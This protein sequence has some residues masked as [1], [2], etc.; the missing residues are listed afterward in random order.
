MRHAMISRSTIV[1]AALCLLTNPL[2][3][4]D[5]YI[6][7]PSP[8]Y[9][10]PRGGPPDCIHEEGL[11]SQGE[12]IESWI[13]QDLLDAQDIGDISDFSP[14]LSEVTLAESHSAR[15]WFLGTA[16]FKLYRDSEGQIAFAE[17]DLVSTRKL[18]KRRVR[19]LVRKFRTFLSDSN[20]DF[21]EIERYALEA[22]EK[23]E[24][25]WCLLERTDSDAAWEIQCESE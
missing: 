7:A 21:V 18:S 16:A 6:H 12:S 4:D 22:A 19:R 1:F 17:I 2:R 5:T 20:V 25:D 15:L 9:C 8:P 3:A 13:L 10:T 14:V 24:P 23:A 11:K